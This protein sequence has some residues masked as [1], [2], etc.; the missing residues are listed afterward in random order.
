MDNYVYFIVA[1]NSVKIG[2]SRNPEKRIKDLQVANPKKLVLAAKIKTNSKHQAA[3]V[4]KELHSSYKKYRQN[5]E[6]FHRLSIIKS[7][8]RGNYLLE[9]HQKHIEG[10]RQKFYAS[11]RIFIGEDKV[12]K[13]IKESKRLGATQFGFDITNYDL[14]SKTMKYIEDS[15]KC[16]YALKG[17]GFR[18]N[19]GRRFVGALCPQGQMLKRGKLSSQFSDK[20]RRFSLIDV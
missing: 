8:K 19:S 9:R 3:W 10:P 5:G 1:G 13:F 20:E 4:E 12:N 18:K 14:D 17:A 6:W 15:P 11:F 7:V 16:L 2:R